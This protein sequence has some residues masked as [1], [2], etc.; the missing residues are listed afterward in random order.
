[1]FVARPS[2]RELG[3]LKPRHIG[4]LLVVGVAAEAVAGTLFGASYG[5]VGAGAAGFFQMLQ[6]FFV[7]AISFALGR[8][9]NASSYLQWAMSVLF[10][11]LVI[12]VFDPAFDVASF[13]APE[14][15]SGAG[16]CLAAVA[17]WAAGNVASKILL[18]T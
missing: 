5:R 3:L 4:P 8:E 7:L 1:P 2:R 17:L 12:W 16:L 15:W 10:G 9:R 18:E 13:D 11:A 14:F 6:P